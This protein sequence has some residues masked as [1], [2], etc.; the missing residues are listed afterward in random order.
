MVISFVYPDI[1]SK[2]LIMDKVRLDLG[3]LAFKAGAYNGDRFKLYL[4]L[5][6]EELG[7]T[8]PHK[9]LESPFYPGFYDYDHLDDSKLVYVE[10]T[11]TDQ[12]VWCDMH[13]AQWRPEYLNNPCCMNFNALTVYLPI[14]RHALVDYPYPRV[15]IRKTHY[16]NKELSNVYS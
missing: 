3:N 15:L 10:M 16:I 7:L 14:L 11:E 9:H 1:Q 4:A 13:E 8:K 6:I 12:R 5:L 2:E